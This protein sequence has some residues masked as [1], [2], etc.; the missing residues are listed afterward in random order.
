MMEIFKKLNK[1]I[2]AN[3]FGQKAI[4]QVCDHDMWLEALS[5]PTC[6]VDHGHQLRMFFC[7]RAAL[8]CK[9]PWSSMSIEMSLKTDKG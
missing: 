1:V 9:N 3:F 4:I 8:N 2:K 7:K 6:A 5:C